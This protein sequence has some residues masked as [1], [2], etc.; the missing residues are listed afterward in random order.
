DADKP[1]LAE[2]IQF[3]PG[4]ELPKCPKGGTYQLGAAV[5][6]PPTCTL[7]KQFGHTL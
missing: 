5:K 7:A 4:K 2:V 6:D 3:L 1:V